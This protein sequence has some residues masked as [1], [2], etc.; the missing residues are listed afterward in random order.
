MYNDHAIH[1]DIHV[2]C[3]SANGEGAADAVNYGCGPVTFDPGDGREDKL[4]NT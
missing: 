3:N 4:V 2:Y 1:S